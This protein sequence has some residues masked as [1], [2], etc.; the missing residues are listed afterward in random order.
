M[1]ANS[2]T[3]NQIRVSDAEREAVVERLNAATG[4]GRLTLEEFGERARQ[5]YQARTQGDLARLVEDLPAAG[6]S[7]PPPP[8]AH[9]L[10]SVA[11]RVP[12]GA[13]KRSGRWRL[14]RDTE[15]STVLGTVKLDLAE[16]QI[17]GSE[18]ELRVQTVVGA[19]K[20]WV[21]LGIRVEVTGSSTVGTRLVQ[22]SEG[23]PGAP[24]LRL[25]ID[26]VVG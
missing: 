1:D 11:Q 17:A 12:V 19:V 13:L 7:M 26:T 15:F 5:A 6:T 2:Q 4:E 20:V 22:E 23:Y 3:S 10:P 18:V 8:A 16:A 14:D 25:H 9:G 21:P 24:V